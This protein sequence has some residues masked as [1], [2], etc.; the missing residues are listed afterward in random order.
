MKKFSVITP[1]FNAEKYIEE[2]V[3][4]VIN[5]V[6]VLS[7][8]VELEYIICDGLSTDRT[9][10]LVE[11]IKRQYGCSYMKII[12]ESDSGMYDALT[13]GLKIASGDIVSYINAGDYYNPFAFDVVLDIFT[14]K[15]VKWLTG[16]HLIYNE[17]SQIVYITLPFRYRKEFFAC[18]YYGT[19]LPYVQQESN[20]WCGSLH[21]LID[22]DYL[23]KLRYAGDYYLWL[24]FSQAADLKIV[25][26]CLGGFK[27]HRGQISSDKSAYHKEIESMTRRPNI[28][29]RLQVMVDKILWYA[30]GSVKKKF[31]QDGFFRFQHDLQEWI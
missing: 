3:K 12:S 21:Q 7:N 28:K 31:N 29:D 15:E 16:Y 20:F 30:P 17:K 22:Y 19:K 10:D 5:Q 8:R 2:T 25:E 13:K 9:I 27:I 24:Q 6:A 4:S 23:A 26:S 14:T 11:S 18:G 1:C